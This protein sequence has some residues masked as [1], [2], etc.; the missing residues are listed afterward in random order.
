MSVSYTAVIGCV[1]VL[2]VIYII[3]WIFAKQVKYIIKMGISGALGLAA[4]YICNMLTAQAGFSVGINT[5]TAAVCAVCGIPGFV[6]IL[7]IK[8]VLG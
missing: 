8:A 1:S 4:L 7:L 6:M 5:Y 3:M 2:A